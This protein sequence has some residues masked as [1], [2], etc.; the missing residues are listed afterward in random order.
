MKL[1]L[2]LVLTL[3]LLVIAFSLFAWFYWYKPKLNHVIKKVGINTKPLLNNA[4]KILVK[5]KAAIIK[6]YAV[7]N[8][9]NP[10]L[11]FLVNMGIESGR[12]RFFVYR[13][14]EDSII[15]AGLVTHGNCNSNWLTGKKFGNSMGC[16]CTALGK[17]KV[18]SSY[19]GKFGLA[20]KLYGLDSSNSNSFKRFVV[21]HSHSCVPES[22]V[23]P[24]PICQSL[25]CPTVSPNYLK[26][27]QNIIDKSSRPILLWIFDE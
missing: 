18:G 1:I 4:E 25:G 9:Y 2:R 24:L 16:G 13:L 11:C 17:Y 6:Q 12:N 3:L 14:D 21:L 20:F 26:Y 23:S 19:S 7:N 15:N 27:L 10:R 22:E 8:G 5:N